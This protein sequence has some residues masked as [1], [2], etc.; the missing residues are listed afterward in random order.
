MDV[1]SA[2]T[3]HHEPDMSTLLSQVTC[4]AVTESRGTSGN[5]RTRARS[6]VQVDASCAAYGFRCVRR[7][8][9]L[10]HS[11]PPGTVVKELRGPWD[12]RRRSVANRGD[13]IT[14]PGKCC[15]PVWRN[16]NMLAFAIAQAADRRW[17]SSRTRQAAV[18][19]VSAARANDVACASG[20]RKE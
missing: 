2:S 4:V 7:N 6:D 10:L 1:V 19:R 12:C 18:S 11:L 14:R 15:C 3:V 5:E 16:Q 9:R 20:A 17:P 13:A 8:V